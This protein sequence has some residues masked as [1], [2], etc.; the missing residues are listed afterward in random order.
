MRL[1]ESVIRKVFAFL[2]SHEGKATVGLF[3]SVVCFC[4]PPVVAFP[5]GAVCLYYA[6]H[7]FRPIALWIYQDIREDLN[8][9]APADESGG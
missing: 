1:A 8:D 2:Q 5:A 9:G 6:I 7:Q 3:S 4:W